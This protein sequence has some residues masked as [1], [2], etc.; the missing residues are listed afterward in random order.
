MMMPSATVLMS[1]YNCETYIAEAIESIL[2]Q[3]FT[4]FEFLIINDGSTDSTGSILSSYADPRIRLINNGGNLGLSRSLNTGMATAKGAYIVRMDADDVALPDRLA[5]QVACM[6]RE[7]HIDVCGSWYEMFGDSSRVVKTRADHR[8]I[9]DTLFFR[10]CI[11]HSTVCMR[12]KSFESRPG[13]Y[14]E[15]YRYAQDYE[16]WCRTVGTLTFANIQEVLLRYRVH[17]SQAGRSQIREQDAFADRVRRDN[18]LTLGLRL[19][20]EEESMYCDMIAERFEPGNGNDVRTA[21][22]LLDKIYLAGRA[23]HGSM[24]RNMLRTYMKPLPAK[25]L[26]LKSA[27]PALFIAFVK[28]HLLP[29]TGSKARFLRACLKNMA[30]VYV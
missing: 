3:S 9:R 25:S 18:L 8:D 29:T 5:K 4:E 24:F 10:N 15:E 2:S 21:V 1:A 12:K 22:A 30:G 13:P 26:E 16:L 19:R 14:N 28:W 20:P 7:P 6:E 27:S 23:G 17:G 11:A